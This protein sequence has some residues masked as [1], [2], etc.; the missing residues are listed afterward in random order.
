MFPAACAINP[1]NIDAGYRFSRSVDKAYDAFHA[2]TKNVPK[3]ILL[4]F[5]FSH[6][7]NEG[8]MFHRNI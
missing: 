5:T 4:G 3:Y 7:E 6:P 8:S 1:S 2:L